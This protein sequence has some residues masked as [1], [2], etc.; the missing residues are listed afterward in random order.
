MLPEPNLAEKLIAPDARA[1]NT[2][3]LFSPP[4]SKVDKVVKKTRT[5]KETEQSLRE[6]KKLVTLA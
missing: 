6:Q 4:Q 5:K 2:E 3:R 1:L